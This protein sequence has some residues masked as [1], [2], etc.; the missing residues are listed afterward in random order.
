[1]KDME[2]AD[3]ARSPE[4]VVA[5]L[6]RRSQRHETPCGDGV[7]VWRAWGEGEPLLLMHGAHGSWTHFI[8]NVDALSA[9]RRLLVPDLP[10]YGDSAVPPRPGDGASFAEA[11][12]AGLERLVGHEAPIDV[13]GF[14]FGGVIGGHLAADAPHLVRR[15]ILVDAGGLATPGGEVRGRPV[16][17]LQGEE[18]R[19]AHRYNLLGLM[20]RHE[21]SVDDLALH[22]QALNIPRARVSPKDLVVPD[23]LLASL[24]RVRAPIDAIW[25]EFDVAH[26]DPD[27]QLQVLRRFQPDATMTVIEGA[28]HWPMYERPD[29]FNAAVGR[30]LGV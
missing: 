22:I 23:K 18:L 27:L 6:E 30:L 4:A 12:A 16:R 17:Q 5:D 14:S 29:A 8:R 19:E 2:V 20:L 9:T 21:A 13:V 26:P 11:I 25:G 7:M 3:L 28:G 15:L 24:P 1:M 10:G